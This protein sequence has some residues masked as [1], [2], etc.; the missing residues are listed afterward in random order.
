MKIY[1]GSDHAGVEL[2][3]K[4]IKHFSKQYQFQDE[5]PF[6]NDS[7]DYPDFAFKVANQVIKN[8]ALGIL[9]CGTGFGMSIAA[10][11]VKGIRAVSIIRS[12][13]ASLAKEHNNANI[14]TLSARFVSFEENVRIINNFLNAKFGGERHQ[15]RLDKI[16]ACEKNSLYE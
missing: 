1:I 13:M 2:K 12:D 14:I 6:T 3:E 8:N 5:G 10:N 15:K 4:I 7:V 11:K 16:T 9:I